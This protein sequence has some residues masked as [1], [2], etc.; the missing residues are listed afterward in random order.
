MEKPHFCLYFPQFL[1]PGTNKDMDKQRVPTHP[2][3]SKLRG[4][5]G[6]HPLLEPGIG[7]AKGFVFHSQSTAMQ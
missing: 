1:L 3:H 6:K 2:D 4:G 5:K 7:K